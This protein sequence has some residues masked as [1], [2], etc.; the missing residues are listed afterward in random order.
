M[1]NN[2]FLIFFL[3]VSFDSLVLAN[4]FK[5]TTSQIKILDEGNYIEATNGKAVSEDDQIE[6]KA[7]KFEYK[8]NLKLLKAI[9]GLA[10]FKPDNIEIKFEEIQI[11]QKIQ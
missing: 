11:D 5:F 4:E 10:I 6:I 2:F 8:K 7:K 1:R 3:L 9:D